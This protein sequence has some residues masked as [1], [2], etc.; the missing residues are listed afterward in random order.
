MRTILNPFQ[1]DEISLDEGR[2][3]SSVGPILMASLEN[4]KWEMTASILTIPL[5]DAEKM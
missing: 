4:A 3:S 2:V 5:Y 1:G